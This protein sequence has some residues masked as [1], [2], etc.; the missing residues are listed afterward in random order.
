MTDQQTPTPEIKP[1][2]PPA[3]VLPVPEVPT[4]KREAAIEKPAVKEIPPI[5]AE[6]ATLP[7]PPPAPV[8]VVPSAPAVP[9]KDEVTR[10]VEKMMEEDLGDLFWKMPP[11]AR[12]IFKAKGE[13]TARKIRALL[14]SAKVRAKD[15]LKLI[16]NWLRLIPGVNRFFLEQEAKIKTDRIMNLRK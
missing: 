3:E 10:R 4:V 7:P 6:K 2:V 15:I 14:D 1:L 9:P 16:K 12:E 13:E 8:P 11:A 5:E